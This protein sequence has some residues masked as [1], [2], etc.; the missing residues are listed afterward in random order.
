MLTLQKVGWIALFLGKSKSQLTTCD[1]AEVQNCLHE[2]NAVFITCQGDFNCE[3]DVVH[4]NGASC[5]SSCP[6]GA[7]TQFI[8][9]FSEGQ[10]AEYNATRPSGSAFT[11]ST[12]AVLSGSKNTNSVSTS[13]KSQSTTAKGWKQQIA[14]YASRH[15]KGVTI[16]A[17]DTTVP[18]SLTQSPNTKFEMSLSPSHSHSATQTGD[19][20]EKH[21][22]QNGTF[23]SEKMSTQPAVHSTGKYHNQ[24]LA[25]SSVLPSRTKVA[26]GKS[27]DESF[28]VDYHL[29]AITIT[30]IA[31]IIAIV[32][33]FL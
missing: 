11:N 12:T 30:S 24:T 20:D 28:A 26:T 19:N 6:Q 14:E 18:M 29:P 7:L 1:P 17:N 15:V 8:T 32:S 31:V 10:C 16:L 33:R 13:E 21:R 9:T 25:S 23:V 5:Y 27:H 2:F 4:T 3:C 22:P